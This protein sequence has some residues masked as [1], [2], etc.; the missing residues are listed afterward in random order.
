MSILNKLLKRKSST[1]KETKQA[2][3]TISIDSLGLIYPSDNYHIYRPE[4]VIMNFDGKKY[5]NFEYRHLDGKRCKKHRE[6]IAPSCGTIRKSKFLAER[7]I[8]T[9]SKLKWSPALLLNG[10]KELGLDCCPLYD[11]IVQQLEE[12]P[13]TDVRTLQIPM[14]V[15]TETY[16]FLDVKV[17]EY[18]KCRSKNSCFTK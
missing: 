7:Y 11:Y 1:Q 15:I 10:E 2:K 6:L 18:N 5:D 3:Q 16:A 8:D 12:H 9:M 13:G 17:Q 14:S 4:F